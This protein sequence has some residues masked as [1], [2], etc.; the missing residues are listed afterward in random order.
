M[1][2]ALGYDEQYSLSYPYPLLTDDGQLNTRDLVRYIID[3]KLTAVTDTSRLAYIFHKVLAEMIT[4]AVL[5]AASQTGIRT[6]ALS[7]GVFQ[8]TLLLEL[9]EEQLT[10]CGIRVLR[11]HLI[12]PNDGGIGLGQAVYAM[13]RITRCAV[14]E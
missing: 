13:K 10:A 2:K 3:E 11:H 8:N 1:Y 12:P 4:A 6:A 9:T 14:N 5:A 7:G